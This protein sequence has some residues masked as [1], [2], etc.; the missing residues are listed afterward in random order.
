MK[1]S[2]RNNAVTRATVTL[3]E[4]LSRRLFLQSGSV[5]MG[6]AALAMLLGRDARAEGG[7]AGMPH[8]PAKAKRVIWLTQAGAP[9]QLELLDP[10]PGLKGRPP[11]E[12][13]ASVRGGQ[14][15]TGMTAGQAR[16]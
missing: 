10:K 4:M 15:L 1:R 6:A 8:L 7:L 11:Q 16:F 14:R 3:T 13:P 2:P 9:S 12:L 5:S